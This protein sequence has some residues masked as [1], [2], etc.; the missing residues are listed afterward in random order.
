MGEIVGYR[1]SDVAAGK[2][3]D[4]KGRSAPKKVVEALR[5]A[6]VASFAAESL[7]WRIIK[8][9]A[10]ALFERLKIPHS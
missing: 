4:I 7:D 9:D 6:G 1:V 10:E 3:K 8:R 5:K 2:V